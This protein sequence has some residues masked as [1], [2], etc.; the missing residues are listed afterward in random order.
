MGPFTRPDTKAIRG[1]MRCPPS[2]KIGKRDR[3]KTAAKNKCNR[4]SPRY[5]VCTGDVLSP[6]RRERDAQTS[7]RPLRSGRGSYR[8]WRDHS[9]CNAASDRLLVVCSER[10]IDRDRHLPS[11]L[12]L[13]GKERLCIS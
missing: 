11:T 6:E 3:C 8:A 7:E 13:N 5:I 10:G 9:A 4:S 2:I 12:V 1:C